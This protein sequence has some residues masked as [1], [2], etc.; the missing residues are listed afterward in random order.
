[1]KNYRT[2]LILF[3][4]INYSVVMYS[5]PIYFPLGM[6]DKWQYN[7]QGIYDTFE[8]ILDTLMSNG[9]H[10]SYNVDF[11]NYARLDSLGNV[12]YHSDFYPPVPEYLR[13]KLNAQLNERWIMY[14]SGSDTL[15][16]EMLD[17]NS[18]FLCGKMRRARYITIIPFMG[19]HRIADSIG[20][21]QRIAEGGILY[22]LNAVK[23]NGIQ[24]GTF[25]GIKNYK[26]TTPKEYKLYQNYPNPFNPITVIKFSIPKYSYVKLRVF[27]VIGKEVLKIVEDNLKSGEYEIELDAGNLSSGVYFYTLSA[28]DYIET[29]VM[30]VI[31]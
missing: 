2:F 29:K 9:K 15:Y 5:Q 12:Y 7:Q 16:G 28:E 19:H 31:K 22:T 30:A 11:W 10:Y 3:I 23:I 6:E 21:Y 18:V 8:I 20:V 25:I 17:T 1:M 4:L 26:I 24:C 27:D 13:Y 14:A